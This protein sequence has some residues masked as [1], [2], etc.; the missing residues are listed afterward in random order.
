M[1][2]CFSTL[3]RPSMSQLRSDAEN[4]PSRHRRKQHED[5]MTKYNEIEMDKKLRS[6]Q[7]R[8]EEKKQTVV[9][10]DSPSDLRFGI[11]YKQGS[12]VMRC[13]TLTTR[14]KTVVRG[15]SSR[16]FPGSHSTGAGRAAHRG[17]RHRRSCAR[18]VSQTKIVE[19]IVD[20]VDSGRD[21][22]SEE[23]GPT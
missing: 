5:C 4:Q 14:A 21:R 7:F 1:S 19:Q 6:A 22:R 15:R 17:A 11:R 3:T 10:G 8:T 2:H 16:L 9:D 23:V 20:T 12:R 18:S 13:A